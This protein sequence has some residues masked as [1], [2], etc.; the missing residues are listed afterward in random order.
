MISLCDSGN[1]WRVLRSAEAS[2]IGPGVGQQRHTRAVRAEKCVGLRS[3]A[4]DE[5]V[6]DRWVFWPMRSLCTDRACIRFLPRLQEVR[7]IYKTRNQFS[8]KLS[9]GFEA[10]A[11]AIPKA[12]ALLPMPDSDVPS[13]LGLPGQQM[14]LLDH[15]V[16][17]A[18]EEGTVVAT[19]N[20][21]SDGK[22]IVDLVCHAPSLSM[23]T[24]M[25]P[26]SGHQPWRRKHSLASVW[27]REAAHKQANRAADRHATAATSSPIRSERPIE[28]LLSPG[29]DRS[30]D[31]AC[32]ALLR[33]PTAVQR[34]PLRRVRDGVV[35]KT[36]AP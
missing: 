36:Q 33:M 19:G 30:K 4:W 35:E 23:S 7:S 13:H 11:P 18:G 17:K 14:T 8:D 29:H 24:T 28:P 27:G 32:G 25:P 5:N 26:R 31:A 10:N 3:R 16:T 12:F 22:V 34:I 15:I 20:S 6:R 1:W 21:D 9:E 2:R